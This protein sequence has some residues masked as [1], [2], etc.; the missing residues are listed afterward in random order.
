MK[1]FTLLILLILSLGSMSL[2]AQPKATFSSYSG[3]L[4]DGPI[5]G[6][7]PIGGG[8]ILS[9]AMAAAY[10]LKKRQIIHVEDKKEM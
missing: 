1:K 4:K 5:G 10:G 7:A 9:L 2:F 6:T 8:V 3:K